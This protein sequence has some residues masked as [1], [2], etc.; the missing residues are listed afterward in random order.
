MEF[1]ICFDALSI[2]FCCMYFTVTFL[3]TCWLL[4][5]RLS[6]TSDKQAQFTKFTKEN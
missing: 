5:Q 1:L 6:V 2:V 3:F 4:D